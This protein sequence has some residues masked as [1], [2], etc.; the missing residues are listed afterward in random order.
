MTASAATPPD[1]RLSLTFGTT[2]GNRL[3]ELQQQVLQSQWKAACIEV[4]IKNEPARS[5]FGETLKRRAYGGL[6]DVRLD[7]RHQLPAAANP[8]QRQH[9]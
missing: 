9:P 2:A 1:K 7:H 6:G 3:R 5:F 8:G 4:L